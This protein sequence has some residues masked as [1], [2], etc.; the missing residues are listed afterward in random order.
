M[1]VE[2]VAVIESRFPFI[3]TRF[4]PTP[5]GDLHLGS[6]FT[7]FVSYLFSKHHNAKWL[8]R[9]DDLDKTRTSDI[10]S[11]TLIATLGKAGF[12]ADEEPH[13]QSKLI[14]VY[15]QFL[16]RLKSEGRIFPC[17]CTRHKLMKRGLK[18]DTYD[19]HC[20]TTK[21]RLS[22]QDKFNLRCQLHP[23]EVERANQ[24]EPF[25]VFLETPFAALS[26]D[27]KFPV[28]VN[29][30]GYFSYHFSTVIS[31]SIMN[32]S[33]IIRG[34]DLLEHTPVQ[35]ALRCALQLPTLRHFHTP[36]L[37][38]QFGKKF[39]KQNL[40]P[41]VP[42]ESLRGLFQGF[43]LLLGQTQLTGFSSSLT[44]RALCDELAPHF[45]MEKVPKVQNFKI[46]G[47]G[48]NRPIFQLTS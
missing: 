44:A 18:G 23:S 43:W 8:L 13:F 5:N 47:S 16:D 9:L 28:I 14:P 42:V 41:G 36:V 3:A 45:E 46:L 22:P 10:L 21:P 17:I 48:E 32:I 2:M 29:V 25:D 39:S 1:I 24:L 15:Q 11:Q 38:D 20:L 35:N 27:K 4:A 6:W 7:I 30:D 19:G 33:H 31:D 34:S 37:V 26:P 12:K 40:S